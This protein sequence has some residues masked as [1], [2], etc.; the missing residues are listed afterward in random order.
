MKKQE[1]IDLAGGQFRLAEILGIT[2]AAISQW[3][4]VVP[5]SRVWQLRVVRPEWFGKK[6]KPSASAKE[7]A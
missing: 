5:E 3:G 2:T 1:A 7:A 4:D 6:T